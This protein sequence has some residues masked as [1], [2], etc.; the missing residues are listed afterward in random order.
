MS[1][2]NGFWLSE[3]GGASRDPRRID[4][5]RTIIR[6]YSQVTPEEMQALAQRFLTGDA[7]RVEIVPGATARAGNG[8][9]EA[10]ASR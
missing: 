6:D 4:Q 1:S 8:T 9:A 3:L 5:I 2:G 7:M 10:A